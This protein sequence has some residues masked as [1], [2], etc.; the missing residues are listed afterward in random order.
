MQN[1]RRMIVACGIVSVIG[2]CLLIQVL[3]GRR[4]HT[5]GAGLEGGSSPDIQ[6]ANV[7]AVVL[8]AIAKVDK[9]MTAELRSATQKLGM[10]QSKVESLQRQ[11]ASPVRPSEV[12]LQ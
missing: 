3:Q 2:V 11:L 7:S 8:K 9:Q 10:L 1:E 4:L 6:I 12:R 5:A